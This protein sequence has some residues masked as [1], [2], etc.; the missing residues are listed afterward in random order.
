SRA[1][2]RPGVKR[3]VFGPP[4][5][6]W[7]PNGLEFPRCEVGT[8]FRARTTHP[9]EHEAPF[10][11]EAPFDTKRRS[12]TKRRSPVKRRSRSAYCGG[13]AGSDGSAAAAAAGASP[14]E[15]SSGLVVAS[16]ALASE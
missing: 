2:R 6:V 5:R 15:A 7:T 13:D 4:G 12:M 10:A 16:G 1:K 9:L 11:D 3:T 8:A 14:P